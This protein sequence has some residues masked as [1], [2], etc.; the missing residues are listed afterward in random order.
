MLMVKI[1]RTKIYFPEHTLDV[2]RQQVWF[3]L[4]HFGGRA[5]ERSAA[6]LVRPTV[7]HTCP[8]LLT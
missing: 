4:K 1:F 5:R 3:Q 7:Q 8:K 2:A 6:N